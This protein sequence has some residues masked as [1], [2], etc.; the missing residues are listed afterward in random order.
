MR[1][2]KNNFKYLQIVYVIQQ[3]EINSIESTIEEIQHA[4]RSFGPIESVNIVNV[5]ERIAEAYILYEKSQNAFN[6]FLA[7]Q[8][9]I[10]DL[11]RML[12]MIPADTWHQ[13]DLVPMWTTI[14]PSKCFITNLNDDCL[15]EM[16]KYLDLD[17]AVKMSNVCTRFKRLLDQYHF[18]KVKRYTVF[19]FNVSLNTLRQ[20]MKCIGPHL[21]QLDLKYRNFAKQPSNCIKTEHEERTTYN[22]FQNIGNNLKQLSI[23]MPEVRKPS[24]NLIE[25]FV[26]ALRQITSLEWDV[27]FDCETIEQ[28]RE[29]CPCLE[30]LRLSK[31]IFTCGS[32]HNTTDLHW[33]TLKNFKMFQYMSALNTPC[34]RFLQLF[35][36][37]NPQLKRLKLTNVNKQLF[38]S[39]TEFS[40]N[41]E[42]LE[43]LQNFD[44]CDIH[45]E[46]MLH[47]LQNL[48]N[49][50]VIVVRVKMT[51]FLSD[52]LNQIRCLSQMKHLELIVLLRN[53]SPPIWPLEHFPHAH[54][55]SDIMIEGNKM[56]LNINENTSDFYFS[57]GNTTLVNIIYSN[58]PRESSHFTLQREIQATFNSS[59]AYSPN[60]RQSITF[61]NS[62]CY[63]HIRVSSIF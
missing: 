7:I 31:R 12:Q 27:V 61:E 6:A 14:D 20:T 45:S 24:N 47:L 3:N 46:P 18:P 30:T 39:V 43:M 5:S 59:E 40:K 62:D 42:H 13:S 54:F 55:Y 49:L 2:I 44:L 58:N 50:K 11:P 8:N 1:K 56:T 28:L 33:P 21:A 60:L 32:H 23:H 9:G 41:L 34:Q 48:P 19:I 29:L 4:F 35:I 63:Q 15:L 22:V 10:M 36:Q 17:A 51:E 52:V 53:Y 37:S 38:E 57:D 16:F 25:L 26:P